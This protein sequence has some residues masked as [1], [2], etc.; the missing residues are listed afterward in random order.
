MSSKKKSPKK[1][2]TKL[3][4]TM[5]ESLS[6]ISK[7]FVSP[8]GSK[9]KSKLKNNSID[10]KSSII[11]IQLVSSGSSSDGFRDFAKTLTNDKVRRNTMSASPK[12]GGISSKALTLKNALAR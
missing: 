1:I 3:N 2:K 5:T 11:N 9:V 8:K 10:K 6:P 12:K 4:G 7:T